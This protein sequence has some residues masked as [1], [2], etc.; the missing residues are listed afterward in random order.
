MSDPDKVRSIQDRTGQCVIRSGH[1]LKGQ[2]CSGQVTSDRVRSRTGQDS[3]CQVMSISSQIM[4]CKD[5]VRS[6]HVRL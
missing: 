3:S 4:S 1:I 5:N 6:Y 2:I